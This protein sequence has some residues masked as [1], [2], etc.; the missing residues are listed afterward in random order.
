MLARALTGERGDFDTDVPMSY[1][2][3]DREPIGVSSKNVLA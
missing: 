3:V 1:L 2:A